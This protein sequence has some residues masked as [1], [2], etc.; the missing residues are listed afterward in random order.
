VILERVYLSISSGMQRRRWR[1]LK[2]KEPSLFVIPE[3]KRDKYYNYHVT[4]LKKSLPCVDL[5]GP[6]MPVLG[7]LPS[8]DTDF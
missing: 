6:A 7:D 1:E 5:R 8:G 3:V 4:I 2:K